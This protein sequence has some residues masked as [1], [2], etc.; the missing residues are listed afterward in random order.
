MYGW[1]A[2]NYPEVIDGACFNVKNLGNSSEKLSHI[3]VH[4]NASQDKPVYMSKD[5]VRVDRYTDYSYVTYKT[6]AGEDVTSGI[7]SGVVTITEP[8]WIP[9]NIND[10]SEYSSYEHEMLLTSY[11]YTNLT[12]PIKYKK[13]NLGTFIEYNEYNRSELVNTV[14]ITAEIPESIINESDNFIYN[15]NMMIIAKAEAMNNMRFALRESAVNP[16]DFASVGSSN[17]LYY[18]SSDYAWTIIHDNTK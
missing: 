2:T 3:L 12:T 4:V 18:C 8:S 11:I 10:G 6:D 15:E 5:V 13:F 7:Y 1:I 16:Y 17:D 14:E 9:F